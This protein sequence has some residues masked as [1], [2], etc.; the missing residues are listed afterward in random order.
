MI[1]RDKRDGTEQVFNYKGE[2][3]QWVT[4]ADGSISAAGVDE[5]NS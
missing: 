4:L 3:V 1:W 5:P 2:L